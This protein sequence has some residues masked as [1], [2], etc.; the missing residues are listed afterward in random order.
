[1]LTLYQET[2]LQTGIGGDQ[3]LLNICP[4]DTKGSRQT[5]KRNDA[6]SNKA[7]DY[8][9]L[10]RLFDPIFFFLYFATY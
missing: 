5:N 10:S 4:C 6:T 2:G 1:L 9:T 7:L 3:E 8:S